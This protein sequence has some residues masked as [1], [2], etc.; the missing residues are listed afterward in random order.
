[1]SAHNHGSRSRSNMYSNDR[2]TNWQPFDPAWMEVQSVYRRFDKKI[3]KKPDFPKIIALP[4]AEGFV[5]PCTVGAV[6]E[7]L[8]DIDPTFIQG[9]RAV[10]LLGGTRKQYTTWYSTVAT[11]G[12]YWR[13]C[14]FLMAIPNR[15]SR[16]CLTR[17]QV[18]FLND[19]LI[20]EVGHHVDQRPYTT[21][22]EK[23]KFADAFAIK[24]GLGHDTD[25]F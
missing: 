10:F 3:S 13:D 15:N 11:Y 20:H 22:K 1:M 16:R 14:I 21:T 25:L 4:L 6:E 2:F 12:T 17:L 23:E 5:H 19:V 18:M 24:Y 8:R 7:K 9:L